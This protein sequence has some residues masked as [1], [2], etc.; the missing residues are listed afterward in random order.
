MGQDLLCD[1][2]HSINVTFSH[3][4][5]VPA[6]LKTGAHP[7]PPRPVAPR[8]DIMFL[9][10]PFLLNSAIEERVDLTATLMLPVLL[11]DLHNRAAAAEHVKLYRPALRGRIVQSESPTR[12]SIDL[13]HL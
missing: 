7:Y 2:S 9:G 12:D 13:L 6:G 5:G 3:A 4:A 10:G 11:V 1:A 8:K